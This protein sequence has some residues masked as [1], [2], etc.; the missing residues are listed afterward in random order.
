MPRKMDGEGLPRVCETVPAMRIDPAL[1]LPLQVSFCKLEVFEGCL[2]RKLRFRK[3]KLQFLR[4]SLARDCAKLAAMP[5]RQAFV[6]DA[7]H[8]LL[9]LSFKIGAQTRF[10]SRFLERRAE[11]S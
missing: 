1:Q 3:L 9:L 4:G 7:F 6:G 11:K 10:W 5:F 8:V 2:A